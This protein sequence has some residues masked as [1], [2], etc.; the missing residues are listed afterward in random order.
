MKDLGD[1][2]HSDLVRVIV[3]LQERVA[4]LEEENRQLRARLS[5]GEGGATAKPS[6]SWAKA[7]RSERAKKE[8][9][10]RDRPAFR[11]RDAPTQEQVH[12][13]EV[14]PDC[15][16]KLSGGWQVRRRQVMEIPVTRVRIV[17]HV[18][19]GRHCGV[20]GKDVVAPLDLSEEVVGQHR[21]GVRLMSLIALWRE[22]GRL[23]LRTIQGL[24]EAQYGLHL[25]VGELVEILHTVAKQ[26]AQAYADIL[27]AVRGS[28]F[29]HGDETGW[30]EDGENG[31]LWS[32][33]TPTLRYLT[34]AHSRGADVAKQ[35]LQGEPATTP[36]GV[37]PEQEP[38]CA[39]RNVLLSDFYAGYSWYPGEHQ[40]CW[41]HL[42]GDLHD[43]KQMH[44]SEGSVGEWV[45]AVRGVY[46]EAKNW[47]AEH[48]E[49][50]VSV[51]RRQRF[52]YQARLEELGAPY[53]K[54]EGVAQKVLAERLMRFAP[55]LFTFVEYKGVPSENNAAERALRPS[56]IARK[57]SGGTRSPKGSVTRCVLRSLFGTW[58]LQGRDLLDTCR[59][60]LVGTLA[61][62]A[63]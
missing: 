46:E 36:E 31:Y 55:E 3:S 44:P 50:I 35:V 49:A 33:S 5:G 59:L 51:R 29:V 25:S 47:V 21:V 4:A 42:L 56:V 20:C 6:P 23:P 22:E 26:G 17:E 15:A 13:P 1:L 24:L 19:Y 62:N 32:F 58:Q 30:R 2:S 34:Y 28:E 45:K 37:S 38:V 60:M 11:R 53:A 39:F 41:V 40:R 16:R 57:I 63:P 48:P 14:C 18:V 7:N 61:P 9:K 52:L 12:A 8:R 27:S 43:L 10:K 54:V